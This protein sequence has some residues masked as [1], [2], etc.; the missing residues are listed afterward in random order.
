MR[1][2]NWDGFWEA[3][4]PERAWNIFLTNLDYL[5][6][7]TCPI[8]H[9]KFAKE[10][11]PWITNNILDVFKEKDAALKRAKRT[12]NIDNTNLANFLKNRAKYIAREATQNYHT[13]KLERYK[14]IP[15]AIGKLF[16]K[17]FLLVRLMPPS[18]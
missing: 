14:K 18:T 9:F 17:F 7:L 8:K 12:K 2:T 16:Q 6:G 15:K 1:N 11:K 5:L 3:D 13:E 4:T 10:K